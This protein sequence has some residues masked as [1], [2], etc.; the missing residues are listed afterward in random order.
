MAPEYFFTKLDESVIDD[1]LSN[2]LDQAHDETLVVNCS[3]RRTE[4]L[5]CFEEVVQIRSSVV[6]ARV[7]IAL[8]IERLKLS[9]LCGSFG[10]DPTV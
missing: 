6:F 10:V 2:S 9:T 7:A 8:F 4:H 1:A 5:I 3:E